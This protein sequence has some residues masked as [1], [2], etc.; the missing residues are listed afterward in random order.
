[1]RITLGTLRR[2]IREELLRENDVDDEEIRKLVSVDDIIYD[3]VYNDSEMGSEQSE[4]IFTMTLDNGEQIEYTQVFTSFLPKDPLEV[5]EI[6]VESLADGDEWGSPPRPP[7][8]T[9]SQE[10]VR[11]MGN[12]WSVIEQGLEEDNRQYRG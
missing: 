2:I 7:V 11:L 5:A 6:A 8:Q 12:K 9:T 3:T 4:A 10:F 1:M